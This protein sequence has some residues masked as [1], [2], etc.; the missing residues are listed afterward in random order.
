MSGA[1]KRTKPLPSPHVLD[2][3]RA[4]FD[5]LRQGFLLLDDNWRVALFNSWLIELIGYPPGVVRNGATAAELVAAAHALGHYHGLDVTAAYR[6]WRK[7]LEI[8]KPGRHHRPPRR[9]AGARDQLFA[10]RPARLDH[11]L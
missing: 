4:T 11:H 3:L 8:R 5:T 7:R 10:V 6:S 2:L 1:S 9:R